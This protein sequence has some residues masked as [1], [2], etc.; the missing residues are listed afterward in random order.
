MLSRMCHKAAVQKDVSHRLPKVQLEKEI[1]RNESELA[2]HQAI[3]GRIEKVQKRL[4][5]KD[6]DAGENEIANG[7]SDEFTPLRTYP[8][9]SR[10][11]T[12]KGRV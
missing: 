8:G 5:E 3:R 12:H 10:E 4:N 2:I 6:A 1:V 11:R 7:R 9:I